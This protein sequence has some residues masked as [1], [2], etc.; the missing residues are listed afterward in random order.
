MIPVVIPYY[1]R[2]DQLDKCVAHLK[3][4][5]IEPEIFIRDNNNDNVYFTAAINEGI[6]KYLVQPCK[7]IVIL[8]QDMYLEPVAVEKMVVFMDSHPDCGIG[9]PLQIDSRN[10]E[11]VI[12]AGGQESF[13]F[14]KH[15]HGPVSEFTEDKQIFWSNGAC[16]MFR[17]DMIQ[18]IGLLDKNLVLIGSDSDYCFT[19]RLRGWQ[20]WKIAGARGV[21][22]CG[23]SGALMDT[24]IEKLKITDMIYFGQKWLTGELYKE[25]AYEGKKFTTE[26][27]NDIMSELKQAKID[28]EHS[29]DHL[30]LQGRK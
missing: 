23:A 3:N 26:T 21:H 30:V 29:C 18:E 28:L 5:T 14:G 17:K 11:H 1:K 8:N 10:P 16:M 13:P 22:E 24:H 4:Q 15:V 6:K 7:Y 27:I 25:L 9:A 12:F 19:A 20:V 2:K